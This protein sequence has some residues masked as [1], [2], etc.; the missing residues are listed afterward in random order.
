MSE[1]EVEAYL[2]LTWRE[3]ER[4]CACVCEEGTEKVLDPP[5]SPPPASKSL[6]ALSLLPPRLPD[7]A[8][9]CPGLLLSFPLTLLVFVFR[10]VDPLF[11]SSHT[12]V[13]ED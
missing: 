7:P 6:P 4:V 9:P 2:T 11:P 3:R 13:H 12:H 10:V 8:L 1:E 5:P